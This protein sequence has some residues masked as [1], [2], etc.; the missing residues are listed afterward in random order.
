MV[1]RLRPLLAKTLRLSIYLGVVA[2][3]LGAVGVKV[4]HAKSTSAAL[5]LGEPLG[6]LD[7]PPGGGTTLTVNGQRVHLSAGRVTASVH[8]VLARLERG[9]REHADGL[10]DDLGSLDGLMTSESPRG[11]PGIG[12]LRDEREGHGV[13]VCFAPGEAVG[14]ETLVARVRRFIESHD[15]SEIGGMRYVTAHAEADG[16]TRVTATWTDEHLLLDEMFPTSGDA[17]GDDPSAAP[18]PQGRRMLSARVEP[19]RYG[20]FIYAT[21][22]AT[23]EEALAR[24]HGEIAAR[25]FEAVDVAERTPHARTYRH[26][27]V[28]VLVTATPAEHGATLSIIE[29]HYKMAQ[30]GAR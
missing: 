24:Y 30:G 17:K 19:A 23:P 3:G 12:I 29:S 4:V 28:D 25:Q 11:M 22:A 7:V 14:P 21:D 6:R 27:L 1:N 9:C 5:A 16:H 2:V 15:V 10:A 26:G 20:A 13:V 18:R 8:D